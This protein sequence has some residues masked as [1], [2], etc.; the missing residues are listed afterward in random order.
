MDEREITSPVSLTL[1]DGRLNPEAVGWAR[2]P[3][4][5]TDRIGRGRVGRG[6]NKRWEYWAVTTP[7]HVVALV[8]SDIDYAAVHGIWVLD[9]RTG[10]AVAHDAI[11]VTGR[12]ATLPGTL[13]AGPARSRTK[14][15]AHRHRR[16]R[17]R[18]PAARRGSPGADRRDG[19]PASGARVPGPWW[20][21]GPTG[22][23]ST[24]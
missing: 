1:A 18:H 9:R 2:T 17:G 13:G 15:V 5:D 23:S 11:G 7:T 8:L 10:E 12:S 3:L 22:S 21:R 6:R 24:R 20:S 19:A 16:G 14:A 4:V